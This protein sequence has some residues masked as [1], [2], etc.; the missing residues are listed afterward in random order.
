MDGDG[1]QGCVVCCEP[2]YLCR[3][4]LID[5]LGI[6]RVPLALDLRYFSEKL[7]GKD[8]RT[9]RNGR[10]GQETVAHAEPQERRTRRGSPK[11]KRPTEYCQAVFLVE[12]HRITNLM[13]ERVYL[14]TG[15]LKVRWRE[16]DWKQ[17][18]GEFA[19]ASIGA[20][21]LEAEGRA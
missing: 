6:L 2:C 16:L 11:T 13:I 18:I 1:L 10:S 20:E 9:A 5:S 12:R 14:V 8:G 7:R 3:A 21:L 19:P 17:V 4:H 15:G